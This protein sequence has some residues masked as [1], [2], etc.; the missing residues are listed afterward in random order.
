M[1]EATLAAGQPTSIFSQ[2]SYDAAGHLIG[3]WGPATGDGSGF[4]AAASATTAYTYNSTTG[5]KTAD[6][7]QL[8]SVGTPVSFQTATPTTPTGGCNRPSPTAR[9]K[10]TNSIQ[11]AT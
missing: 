11:T 4:L 5:L 10:P 8:Q 9:R 7:L 2:F 1:T 3:E 6:N